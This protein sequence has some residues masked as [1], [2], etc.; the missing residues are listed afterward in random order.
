MEQDGLITGHDE[1]SGA[2]PQRRVF[3]CTAKGRR[4][5]ERWLREPS[6]RMSELRTDFPPRL[7]FALQRGPQDVAQLLQAQRGACQ[8]ELVRMSGLRASLDAD[9]LF[10]DTVYSFRL[11]QI[12]SALDWLE[13]IESRLIGAPHPRSMG[14]AEALR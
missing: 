11:S 4:Q 7:Y 12:Q 14:Q 13:A 6:E 5:F 3:R 1:R 8:R 2:R 10:R 9:S